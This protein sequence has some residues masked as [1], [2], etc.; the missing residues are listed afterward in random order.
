MIGLVEE[1]GVGVGVADG[2]GV[3]VGVGVAEGS[4]TE[5]G[6]ATLVT[7]GLFQ[8]N[9]LPDLIHVNVFDLYNVTCP[10]LAQAFPVTGIAA[11][12]IGKKRKLAARVNIERLARR[13][14]PIAYASFLVKRRSDRDQFRQLR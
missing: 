13:R 1:V 12:L 9:F 10:N 7:D 11:T 3:G 2:V 6:D 5:T 14:I 4:G 8:T